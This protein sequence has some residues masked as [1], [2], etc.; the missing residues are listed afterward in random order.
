MGR[1]QEARAQYQAAAQF[2]A[3]YYGQIARGRLGMSEMTVRPPPQLT[4]EERLALRNVDVV[5]AVEIL[6]AI[7]ERDLVTVMAS[8]LADRPVDVGVMV[9][10]GELAARNSDARAMLSL[11]KTAMARGLPLDHFAF[12][13][14]GIPRYASIGPDLDR[15]MVYAIT[16]QE[17]AFNPR[18]VSSAHALGLM[19]VTPEAG[20]D[21]ARRFGVK[22]DQKR[23]LDDPAYNVQMGS[24]EITGLLQDY[25]GS[26]ILTFAG[27]NAGRGRAQEWIQRYGDPRDPR[28][29][30]IDWVELIPFSE[31]RYYVQRVMENLAVYRVRLGGSNRMMIEADLRRGAGPSRSCAAAEPC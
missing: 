26:Y 28:V 14:V 29:D 31:T 12:P 10:I 15:A 7:N 18:D 17:S 25:R 5:R 4:A 3:A 27:Y 19:Q 2:T 21:T 13:D 8:D 30:P 20:R 24:A 6:Y 1:Q 23:L 16:K 11:G 22:F 9:M